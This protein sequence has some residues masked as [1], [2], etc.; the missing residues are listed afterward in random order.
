MSD[1]IDDTDKPPNFIDDKHT[2]IVV[3]EVKTADPSGLG[4]AYWTVKAS[5]RTVDEPKLDGDRS[6]LNLSR[7]RGRKC[8]IH[9]AA[10]CG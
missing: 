8:R 9:H 7:V 4:V 5:G 3:D 1:V 10:V 6:T 2:L